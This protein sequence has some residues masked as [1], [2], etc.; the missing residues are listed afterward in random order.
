MTE[1]TQ[2]NQQPVARLQQLAEATQSGSLLQVR[3]MLNGLYP[4]EIAHLIEALTPEK[5]DFVW[6]L[7]DPD[8]KGDVLL[9]VSDDISESLIREM[10]PDQL[11]ALTEA[12]AV[13]DMADFIQDLPDT[14][15]DV[16]LQS[17]DSQDRRRVEAI[18]HYPED[19]AGGL[20]NT[21]T[22]TVRPDVTVDVVLRYL[23]RRGNI[24]QIT[25]SL[26]V[27][28]RNNKFLG[29]VPLT[30]LLTRD[31]E[32]TIGELLS[33]DVEP[34]PAG[35]PNTEVAALFEYRDLVSAPVVDEQGYLLG[36]IT[37]DDV[38]DVI[39]ES[40]EQ[41]IL[42]R[43][44][45]N[46]EHD[47]F[48]PVLVSTRRRAIWL[49]LN[50]FTAFIA[51]Y[52]IGLFEQTID[53]LVALAVLM[54]IVASMG[55]I[56]G[57]QTLTLVIRGMALGQIGDTNARRL[58]FKELSVGLLNG[59]LWALIV[60]AITVLW[61]SNI[62]LGLIIA[63]AMVINLIT[64]AFAGATLPSFLRKLG[65]DPALAGGVVLTTITDVI[66]FMAFLGLA[67]IYLV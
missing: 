40:A 7:I 2:E 67:A 63:A 3:L 35:M 6:E 8:L 51:S 64:A 30:Y 58:M 18:L 28:T 50:L 60:A 42:S 44:G 20:M 5:R 54:P 61:F 23:R 41:D 19:T 38:V 12:L 13:D 26:I 27:V 32:A 11:V 31:L 24:P 34:I 14:V 37:V 59:L 55:G 22:I 49:G 65:A 56:A 43:A 17:L 57:N 66:G 25:D 33:Q 29:T 15:T 45:L 62:Q 9:E 16:V 53:Q 47:M 1:T 39:R 52:V 10:N 21:D 36:R 4:A 46:E 48:A